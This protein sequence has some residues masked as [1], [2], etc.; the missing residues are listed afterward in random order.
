M[1]IMLTIG[2]LT[3]LALV[4]VGNKEDQIKFVFSLFNCC[5]DDGDLNSKVIIAYAVSDR[6][7][8]S[9]LAEVLHLRHCTENFHLQRNAVQHTAGM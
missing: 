9:F 4:F 6:P 3:E 2:T 1:L 5:G 8:Y 7:A